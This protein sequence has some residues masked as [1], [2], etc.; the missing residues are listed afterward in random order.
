[1]AAWSPISS[2]K[3][4]IVSSRPKRRRALKQADGQEDAISRQ[5]LQISDRILAD[6]CKLPKT[7]D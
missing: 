7:G 1:M 3:Q 4:R 6:S 2:A 5:T